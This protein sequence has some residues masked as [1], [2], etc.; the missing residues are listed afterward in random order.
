MTFDNLSSCNGDVVLIIRTS[1]NIRRVGAGEDD[2]VSPPRRTAFVRVE[3]LSDV[4]HGD[5]RVSW[6]T[7]LKKIKRQKIARCVGNDVRKSVLEFWNLRIKNVKKTFAPRG[8]DVGFEHSRWRGDGRFWEY[9]WY[10]TLR[11]SFVPRSLS[12]S[13]AAAAA[14]AISIRR[15][16][17]YFARVRQW[18]GA[19]ARRGTERRRRRPEK[20]KERLWGEGER[21]GGGGGGRT[22]IILLL[23]L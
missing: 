23:L 5:S 13:A 17:W 16:V 19:A 21:G 1:A 14:V 4:W 7:T 9:A 2:G 18:A 11:T 15:F 12:V 6:L 22:T 10:Q 8:G 20:R 3:N